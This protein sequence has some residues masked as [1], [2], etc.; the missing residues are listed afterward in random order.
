MV[1]TLEALPF[2]DKK[3]KNSGIVQ[4]AADGSRN[5]DQAQYDDFEQHVRDRAFFYRDRLV[6]YLNAN[7][8]L[9]PSYGNCEPVKN[10]SIGIYLG[11]R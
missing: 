11:P 5:L 1:T 2:L 3:I 6:T 9:F 4:S 8:A 7:K 10:N